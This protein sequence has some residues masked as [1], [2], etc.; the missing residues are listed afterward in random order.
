MGAS[1]GT[2]LPVSMRRYCEGSPR[3]GFR[4]LK[5]CREMAGFNTGSRWLLVAVLGGVLTSCAEVRSESQLPVPPS[6]SSS[7]SRDFEY[8][9]LY[10]Q[11][12]QEL[13]W[14]MSPDGTRIR[15]K[16]T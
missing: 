14:S 6:V 12:Y 11:Q 3:A 7:D 15:P 2:A 13:V 16:D 9:A 10:R 1:E 5:G 4:I 8:C